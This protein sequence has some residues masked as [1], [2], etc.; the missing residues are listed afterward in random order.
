MTLYGF[1][2]NGDKGLEPGILDRISADG[3]FVILKATEGKGWKDPHTKGFAARFRGEGKR[4]GWYHYPWPDNP[5]DAE[6]DNLL[7]HAQPLPG[8]VLALDFEPDRHKQ[9]THPSAWPGWIVEFLDKLDAR[10]GAITWLYQNEDIGRPVQA[11]ATDEQRQRIHRAPLW[12]AKYGGNPGDLM[13]WP[14]YGCWQYTDRVIDRDRIEDDALWTR[15]A[16][17]T[18]ERPHADIDLNGDVWTGLLHYGQDNSDSVRRMQKVLNGIKLPPPGNLTIDLT[19]GRYGP[20]TDRVVR[21]WQ[22]FI[23]DTPDP[24]GASSIGPK[25]A[26]RLFAGTPCRLRVGTPAGR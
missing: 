6:I 10:T 22:A 24:V 1:D 12:K 16:I 18:P 9:N 25:Q 11:H 7:G 8:E 2:I 26:A 21:T 17:P 23:G 20:Q 4:V 5:V 15:T 3:S 19:S 14:Q 13:G